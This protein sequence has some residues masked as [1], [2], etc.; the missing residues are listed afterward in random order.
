MP[1]F[2]GRRIVAAPRSLISRRPFVAKVKCLLKGTAREQPAARRLLRA[3]FDKII[4]AVEA[5]DG[6]AW[7]MF[8]DRHGDWGRD[9]TLYM[10][11]RHGGL[12][13]RELGQVAGGM[14]YA[15]VSLALHRFP[16][17][18]ARDRS[19]QEALRRCQRR[20]EKGNGKMK[21]KNVEI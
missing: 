20:L 10:A 19:L 18:L 8:R 1:L 13:L 7:G 2:P 9:L 11:R 5:E 3:G 21:C 6:E 12:K 16:G 14:D 4:A 17:R 15:A